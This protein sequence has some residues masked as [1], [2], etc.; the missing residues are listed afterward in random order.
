LSIYDGELNAERLDNVIKQIEVYCRVQKIMD[1]DA[2]LQLVTLRLGGTTL[3]WW[4]SRTQNDLIQQ[5]KVISSWD[6]FIVSLR[7]QFYPL[8]YMQ[9][10]IIDWQ[11]L[12]QGKGKNVQVYTQEFKKKALSLGIPFFKPGIGEKDN[13]T[14]DVFALV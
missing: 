13:S 4:Q 9:T 3:I 12:R 6:E 8:A 11:H 14:L 5:G 2:K 7:K 10:T 1:D